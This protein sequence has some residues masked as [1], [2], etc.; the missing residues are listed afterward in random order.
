MTEKTSGLEITSVATEKRLETELKVS[1]TDGYL[2]C[3]T[4]FQ[5]AKKLDVSPRQV[6]DMAN[7]L[8]IKIHNCQLGCFP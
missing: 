5:I 7:K 1:L 4:A 6:G 8:K 2:P 3:A